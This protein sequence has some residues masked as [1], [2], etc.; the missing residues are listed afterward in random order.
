MTQSHPAAGER[1]TLEDLLLTDHPRAVRIA[2]MS[3]ALAASLFVAMAIPSLRSAIQ[4]FDQG[5]Y[6]TTFPVK[7]GPLTALA[8]T[9][10]FLGSGWFLWPLRAA[11]TVYLAVHRRLVK[12]T[13][14][15]APIAISEP[16]VGLLKTAY[17]RARP[18]VALMDEVSSAF[19]SGHA[20]AGAVVALSLVMVFVAP[21]PARRNLEIVAAGFAM[22]MA[23]SRLYLG[24]HWFTDV[25][26]GV[27]LGAAA[28]IGAAAV[29]QRVS[30]ERQLRPAPTRRQVGDT[31]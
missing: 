1:N 28:A 13:A 22:L 20:V 12:L 30:A 31:S 3:W 15:L 6:D 24:V 8:E 10:A 19:P 14:W 7:W 26:A 27:A 9:L 4:T 2:V 21:G 25:V 5:L 29:V 18:P 23:G 17:D 11:V 16:L